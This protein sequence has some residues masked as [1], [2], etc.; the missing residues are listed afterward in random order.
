MSSV[1]VNSLLLQRINHTSTSGIQ[2]FCLH[3]SL[4]LCKKNSMDGATQSDTLSTPTAGTEHRYGIVGFNFPLDTLY[5][6]FQKK[7]HP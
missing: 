3:R 4:L 5:T 7:V 2:L 1:C 6:V